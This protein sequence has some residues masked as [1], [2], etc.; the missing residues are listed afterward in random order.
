MCIYTSLAMVVCAAEEL[1]AAKK[2][3][4]ACGF[5]VG[6]AWGSMRFTT[7]HLQAVE[8]LEYVYE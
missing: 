4:L 3:N 7:D 5:G 1:K 2:D 6:L 8:L